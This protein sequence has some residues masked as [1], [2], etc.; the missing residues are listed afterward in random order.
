MSDYFPF[1]HDVGNPDVLAYWRMV[2]E[3]LSAAPLPDEL[4]GVGDNILL[5]IK[6]LRVLEAARDAAWSQA[7]AMADAGEL[8]MN[9]NGAATAALRVALREC[10]L[11]HEA[12]QSSF[13]EWMDGEGLVTSEKS[14]AT[15]Q[16]CIDKLV[17]K[18]APEP[19]VTQARRMLPG[20]VEEAR[21]F[22]LECEHADA[23]QELKA[24]L[25]R[26]RFDFQRFYGRLE[27]AFGHHYKKGGR[28]HEALFG[29]RGLTLTN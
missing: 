11:L 27:R 18:Q 12:D 19:V 7:D 16:G 26:L 25:E 5:I 9:G 8:L 4:A 2:G 28:G 13:G 17:E 15:L 21:V 29:T 24:K 6:D 3:R 10:G 23:A 20:F 14:V 22:A 1:S